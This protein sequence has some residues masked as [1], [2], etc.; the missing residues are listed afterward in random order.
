MTAFANEERFRHTLD[1]MLEGCQIIGFDWRYLYV[2]NAAARY[3]RQT[4]EDLLGYT[5]MEKYPGIENTELFALMQQCMTER[6]ARIAEFEFTYP[7]GG[8]SW[9][10]FSIQP[11][12]DGIF[13]LTLDITD[14]KKAEVASQDSEARLNGIITSAMD[15]IISV[16][17]TQR[18]VLFNAA[19]ETMFG[20]QA[21]EVMGQSLGR[22][23]P[24]RFRRAH[25]EHMRVFGRSGVT[26]RSMGKLGAII[27]LRANGEEFPIE[28]SISQIEAADVRF[29]TVILRDITERKNM[30]D[31]LQESEKRFRLLVEGVKEYAILT[32]DPE[33]HVVSWN[34]GARRIKGYQA[35]DIIGQHISVFYTAEDRVRGK[36]KEL[37]HM[38]TQQGSVEDEGWRVR[39]DGSRIWANVSISA[40][41]DEQGQLLGFAKITRDL[42]DRKEA[43]AQIRRLNREL[44]KRVRERTVQLEVANKELEAFAYSVSHDLRA[45]LRAMSGFSRILIQDYTDI[46]DESGQH[47]LQRIRENASQMGNLIDDL[48]KFSRLIREPVRRETINVTAVVHR[49]LADLNLESAA[50]P[51]DIV[52]DELPDC[53]ADFQLLYQVFL[54]LIENAVKYS[55]QRDVIRIHVGAQELAPMAVGHSQPVYFVRDN[56]IGFDMAYA[57]KIFGVFQR[58]HR[59]EEFEGTGVGLALVQRIIHRHSGQ[60]WVEA[61]VDQG[62]TFYFTIGF[63]PEEIME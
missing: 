15:A 60:I 44:E 58:L 55:R 61:V 37:L 9:F 18:V 51:L 17:E 1:N 14:R 35:E 7:D 20:Y 52:V 49:V 19:A 56:G 26:N 6:I 53:L 4:K 63:P 47:Y 5:V 59:A 24:Q 2:N 50:L 45:P 25:S 43:E 3:G 28:A 32:L 41:R 30:E 29:Y 16:D 36:A 8:T 11:E 22:F 40:L 10:Q 54:N 39:Q 48:L 21:A 33:G 31:A 12:P 42:T 13:I 57:E 27:G 23:I 34:D 46:L 38:A 62:A